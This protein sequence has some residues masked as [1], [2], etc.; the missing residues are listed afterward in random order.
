[1]SDAAV[2]SKPSIW[3]FI[4]YLIA[5][6]WNTLFGYGA[7]AIATYLLTG[8]VPYAYMVASC[9]STVFAITN[10]YIGYKFF[11]FKTKG[12]YLKEYLRFYVVYGTAG[13][14]NLALLPFLVVAVR[15]FFGVRSIFL[16]WIGHHALSLTAASAPYLA[17]AVLT[18]GTVIISFVGHRQ[19]SFKAD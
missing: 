11:V 19:F 6:A 5:G 15:R 17:G 13:L 9:I 14:I 12:N 16:F 7:Y 18:F 8:R 10:A 1:M 3:Q 2:V 4:R